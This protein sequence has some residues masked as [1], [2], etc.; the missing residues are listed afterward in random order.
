[1]KH[2]N[3]NLVCSCAVLVLG[4]LLGC[5]STEETDTQT[6]MSAMDFGVTQTDGGTVSDLDTGAIDQADAG[7]S[8]TTTDVETTDARSTGP[9]ATAGLSR[10]TLE[11][12]DM[13]RAY[14]MYIPDSYIENTRPLDAR[15]SR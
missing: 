2:V 11:H 4:S 7:N 10:H 5:S 6:M 14:L 3:H 13:M 15:F 12:G 9:D 8:M 1:M